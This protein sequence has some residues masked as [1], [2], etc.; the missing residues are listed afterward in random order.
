M[1]LYL[2]GQIQQFETGLSV[3]G[4][5]DLLSLQGQRIAVEVN[6]SIIPK[7]RHA[8]TRLNDGDRVE[9]IQAMGGG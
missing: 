2:N 9:I 7:S 8:E 5:V 4:L 3:A 1:E 6:R